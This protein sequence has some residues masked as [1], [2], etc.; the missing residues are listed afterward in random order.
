MGFLPCDVPRDGIAV[1]KKKGEGA[2]QDKPKDEG[3][4]S[5]ISEEIINKIPEADRPRIIQE[6]TS[7]MM[8]KFPASN[9]IYNKITSK[10]IDKVLDNT[11]KHDDRVAK[12]RSSTRRILCGV[13]IFTIVIFVF[14]LVFFQMQ[15]S[16]DT[17]LNILIAFFSFVGGI[18]GGITLNKF[19]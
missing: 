13:V 16:S 14:L 6:Y 1:P 4:K 2:R 19:L 3:S 8:G 15:E 9:P 11:D 12:D 18:G 7:M 10:H 5:L 17:V